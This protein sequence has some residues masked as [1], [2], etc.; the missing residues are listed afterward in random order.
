M[1]KFIDVKLIIIMSFYTHN[2]T[3]TIHGKNPIKPNQIAKT[4]DL[5]RKN[6]Y[7]NGTNGVNGAK[8]ERLEGSLETLA[9]PKIPRDVSIAIQDKRKELKLNKQTDLQMKCQIPMD[10]IKAIENGTLLLTQTNRQYLHKVARTLG[11]PA[12]SLPK[13]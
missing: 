2:G 5:E 9:Y 12:L 3:T 13:A 7:V 6:I 10:I 8:I 11:M 4:S 1:F